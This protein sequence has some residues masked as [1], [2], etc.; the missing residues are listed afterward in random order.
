MKFNKMVRSTLATAASVAMALGLTA[1]SRDYTVAYVYSIS[2]ANGNISAFGVDYQSGVLTQISGS[3]FTSQLTNPTTVIAAPNGKAIYVIGGSQNAAVESVL[4]GTD[5]KLYGQKTSN[6]TGTYPTAA[7]IDTTGTYLYVTF[8]YQIGYG[9]ANPGPGGISIFPIN[10]DNSLGTPTTVNVGNNPVGIA[11]SAPYCTATPIIPG[12]STCASGHNNV[13][14]YV[15]DQETSPNAT[16]LGYAQN[17]TSGALQLLSGTTCT[18]IT[19]TGAHAGVTPSGVAVDPSA[20]FVYVTDKSS[21]QI[22]GYQIASG[23]SGN[24]TPLTSSPYNTGLL[25]VALVVDPRGKYV[26]TVNFNSSTVSSFS[27]NQADGSLSGTAG[28]SFTTGGTNPTCLTIDPALGIYLYTSNQLSGD[29]S[30][31]QL[32]PNTGALAAIASQPFGSGALP[33]CIT[34]VANGSHAQS[35][36]NP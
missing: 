36:V 13:F 32:N 20:R 22:I 27:L 11:V 34:S 26:Y 6:T 8:K 19:C 16:I 21:N 7:A 14:V 23:T 15:V 31:A 33:S 29:V 4:V 9:P 12:N 2:A 3:P 30:G 24:L 18:P 28:G 35:I 17:Q 25:P 1:C 10:S 5:G